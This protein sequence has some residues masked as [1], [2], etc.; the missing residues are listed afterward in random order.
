MNRTLVLTVVLVAFATG[1]LAY[2]AF[3]AVHMSGTVVVQHR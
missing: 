3:E 2:G 1:V